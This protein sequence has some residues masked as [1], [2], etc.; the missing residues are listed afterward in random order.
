MFI[1][2]VHVY[3]LAMTLGGANVWS[4]FSYGYRNESPSGWLLNP[5]RSRLILFKRNKKSAGN[6]IRIFAH[7][8]YSNDLGEPTSIKSSSQMHLDEA[9]D[10]WHD[11]Q[12]QGW[13]FEELE[14]PESA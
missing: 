2:V 11:L 7:T 9:W 6:N 8:Y 5:G 3:C 4:N 13:T 12:L 10:K 1:L 14:L